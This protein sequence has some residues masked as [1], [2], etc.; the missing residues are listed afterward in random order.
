[1]L[2]QL[3]TVGSRFS[4]PAN[5]KK[6]DPYTTSNIIL[7][8]SFGYSN[9]YLSVDLGVYNLMDKDYMVMNGYPMPKRNFR[10]TLRI[11]F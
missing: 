9:R 4:D 3:L 8:Q 5:T 2:F 10:A 7:T 1:M 11:Q 6:I